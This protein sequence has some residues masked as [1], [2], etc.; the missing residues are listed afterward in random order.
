MRMS[1][2]L[3]YTFEHNTSVISRD[4]ILMVLA[5]VC[6]FLFFAVKCGNAKNETQICFH[7]PRTYLRSEIALFILF[8]TR[9]VQSK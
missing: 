4:F 3:D 5:L 2:C 6:V 7:L 9:V 8:R 1:C